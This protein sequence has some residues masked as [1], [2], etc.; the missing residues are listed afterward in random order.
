MALSTPLKEEIM[1][2]PLCKGRMNDLPKLYV[3]ENCGKTKVFKKIHGKQITSELAE[4][5]LSNG[6]T[7][8][9][10]GFV[11]RSDKRFQAALVLKDGKVVLEF[12]P[13]ENKTGENDKNSP[14]K[15]SFRIRTE[16]GVSGSLFLSIEGPFKK[17][18]FISYGLVP[19]RIAEILGVM[20]ASSYIKHYIPNVSG[21]ALE[22]S[23][24]N[25]DS[26]RYTLRETSP[27]ESAHRKIIQ[28]LWQSLDQFS[29][30]RAVY[31][32][33]KRFKLEGSPQAEGFPRG[34]FPWL[35]VIPV[36]TN[37]GLLVRLPESPDVIYQFTASIKNKKQLN[38]NEFLV[39]P[40]SEN[41]LKAWLYKVQG[42]VR[43]ATGI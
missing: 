43:E 29:S 35:K 3:C 38:G 1:N 23:F 10:D 28:H 8:V 33:R 2:C 37:D 41:V 5:L 30:W 20:T 14:M 4:E 22:L 19:V 15:A 12:P 26:A 25:D 6:R 18:A 7:S 11:S 31:E 40:G 36:S 9:L 24:N 27:R 34:V 16:S 13:K 42:D 39:L 17:N 21:I 32:K